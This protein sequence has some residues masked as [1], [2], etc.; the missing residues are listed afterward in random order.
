MHEYCDTVNCIKIQYVKSNTEDD[1]KINILPASREYRGFQEVP[2]TNRS[3]GHRTP[4]L[5]TK[6]KNKFCPALF[7]AQGFNFQ[8]HQ[9]INPLS[10]KDVWEMPPMM[11]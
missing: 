10:A 2:G 9:G 3:F 1:F 4:N 6:V 11:K 5:K 8:H 7:L